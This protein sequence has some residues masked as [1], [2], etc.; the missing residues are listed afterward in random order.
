MDWQKAEKQSDGDSKPK[1]MQCCGNLEVQHQI[2][3]KAVWNIQ[4][5]L[6]AKL[7]KSPKMSNHKNSFR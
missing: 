7:T 3:S 4:R 5:M 1:E 2:K 6:V